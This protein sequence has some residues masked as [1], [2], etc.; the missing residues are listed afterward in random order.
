M[1]ILLAIVIP[2]AVSISNRKRFRQR[3]SE[4]RQA[5]EAILNQQ[6]EENRIELE[7]LREEKDVQLRTMHET[8]VH[9]EQLKVIEREKCEQEAETLKHEVQKLKHKV[10]K[11]RQALLDCQEE[12]KQLEL[13]KDKEMN[14]RKERLR[15][16]E[17]IADTCKSRKCRKI[18]MPFGPDTLTWEFSD[19]GD[20][21]DGDQ[22][23]CAENQSLVLRE[24]VLD[25]S[26]KC[27][28]ECMERIMVFSMNDSKLGPVL[29]S[30]LHAD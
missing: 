20:M 29:R 21:I 8:N 22:E 4:L 28:V 12:K 3:E 5:N 10:Q 6:K 17:I 2:V 30:L 23:S 24:E 1:A 16:V 18:T 14:E 7:R 11:L 19:D 13:G 26:D 27:L 15:I 25:S 9:E